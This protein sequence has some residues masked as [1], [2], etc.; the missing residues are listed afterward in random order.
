MRQL[1]IDSYDYI[2]KIKE[3]YSNKQIK[4]KVEEEPRQPV[5][6]KKDVSDSR[7]CFVN[8]YDEKT[9]ALTQTVVQTPETT[10]MDFDT[11]KSKTSKVRGLD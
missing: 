2:D 5:K 10:D 11:V 7:I 6:N 3:M 8:E 9:T 1:K 4:E